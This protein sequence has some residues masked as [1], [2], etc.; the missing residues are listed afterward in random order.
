MLKRFR[1]SKDFWSVFSFGI[2]IVLVF[3]SLSASISSP[4]NLKKKAK[5]KLLISFRNE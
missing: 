5:V 2:I 4:Y 3:E 1:N